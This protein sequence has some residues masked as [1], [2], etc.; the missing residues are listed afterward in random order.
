MILVTP[1][2]MSGRSL[3]VHSS[4]KTLALNVEILRCTLQYLGSTQRMA[5]SHGIMDPFRIRL[6]RDTSDTVDDEDA[7]SEFIP[8]IPTNHTWVVVQSYLEK[9][10]IL[11]NIF[12]MG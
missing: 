10:P 12:Q 8:V 4:S 11:T 2:D 5:G 9:I 7:K 1:V 6:K 3:E